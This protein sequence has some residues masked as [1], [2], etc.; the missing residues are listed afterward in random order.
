MPKVVGVLL[1][2][3]KRI[4]FFDYNNIK[5]L[6]N[7]TS[8]VVETERGLQYG[9]IEKE[10]F[11]I[12][13]SKIIGSL[14]KVLRIATDKDIKN[15]QKNI[16]DA[17]KALDKCRSLVD[18][19]NLNMKIIDANYTLNREQLLF[20]FLADNRVDFR[21]LAKDLA[22]IYKTR[23]ELRQVGVRDKAKSIGGMGLCGCTLCCSKFLNEFDSVSI[24]MAKNQNLSL[25]PTKINGV[26]GRLLCCLK[27]EDE[28]YE[29]IRKELPKIGKI[30]ELKQG[31]GKVISIDV[32][33]R[34][35]DVEIENVGIVKVDLNESNK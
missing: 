25:N 16:E 7:G 18:K 13:Q 23:I 10:L 35:Y 20:H 4:Y 9:V 27:Y 11:D 21:N 30:V 32:L 8:V 33:A 29:E 17:K 24:N 15:N 3:Q 1:G 2:E 34:T 5:N 6:K 19:Y 26:C 12:E 14:K 22:S 28:T 31:K